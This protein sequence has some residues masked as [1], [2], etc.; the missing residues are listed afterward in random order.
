VD[1]IDGDF[2]DMF[3]KIDTWLDGC[4]RLLPSMALAMVVLILFYFLGILIS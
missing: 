1:K 2:G 4:F 3:E